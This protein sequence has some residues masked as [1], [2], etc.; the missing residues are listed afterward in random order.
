MSNNYTERYEES[1]SSP[2]QKKLQKNKGKQKDGEKMMKKVTIDLGRS[3]RIDS[4]E[5]GD[6][7]EA[8]LPV[9]KSSRDDVLQSLG[10]NPYKIAKPT[11][12]NSAITPHNLCHYCSR[13]VS[14][15][16]GIILPISEKRNCIHVGIVFMSEM[17]LCSIRCIRWKRLT[18]V[19]CTTKA[20]SS[21]T[22]ADSS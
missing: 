6:S 9:V 11:N 19:R 20:A 1:Y 18:W 14:V 2:E 15:Y 21:V 16:F 17:Y 7:N 22:H 5:S 4:V 12:S 13:R 8:D 3:N 10:Y